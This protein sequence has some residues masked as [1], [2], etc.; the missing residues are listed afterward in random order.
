MPND[1]NVTMSKQ[2]QRNVIQ[3]N[4]ANEQRNAARDYHEKNIYQFTEGANSCLPDTKLDALAA[5][6]EAMFRQRFGFDATPTVR[7]QVLAIKKQYELNNR[8]IFGLY[9][10]GHLVIT[11]KEARLKPDIW[12]VKF[13]QLQLATLVMLFLS[14]GLQIVFSDAPVWKQ[15][16]AGCAIACL[17]A[18]TII[19]FDAVFL[20][21]W[22]TLKNSGAIGS[23]LQTNP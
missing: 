3:T 18:L 8:E 20:S 7:P 14:I 1:R 5:D 4:H 19:L 15:I 17:F 6:N 9:R 21:P 13:F 2:N 10:A 22:R 11:R 23:P 16:L 12:S